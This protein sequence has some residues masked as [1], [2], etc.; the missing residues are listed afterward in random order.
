MANVDIKKLLFCGM[1]GI[2]VVSIGDSAQG[3]NAEHPQVAGNSSNQSEARSEEQIHIEEVFNGNYN[4]NEV[5]FV[6]TMLSLQSR[7]GAANSHWKGENDDFVLRYYS[8]EFGGLVYVKIK[9]SREDGK[10]SLLVWDGNA[11]K[12]IPDGEYKEEIVGRLE[13]YGEI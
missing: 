12:T 2:A 3:M 7:K 10:T 6:K 11:Y 8:S 13:K 9:L 5:S 1:L 4:D